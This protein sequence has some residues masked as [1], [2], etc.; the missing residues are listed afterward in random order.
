MRAAH[1]LTINVVQAEAE[2]DNASLT[3]R[4]LVHRGTEARQRP[5]GATR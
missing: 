3:C 4:V 1:H 5:V 2:A